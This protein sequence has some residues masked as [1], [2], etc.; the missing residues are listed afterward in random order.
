MCS[1]FLYW[2][3]EAL[4]CSRCEWGG[5][6]LTATFLIGR[7]DWARSDGGGGIPHLMSTS[8][9]DLLPVELWSRGDRSSCSQWVGITK[10][11]QGWIADRASWEIPTTRERHRERERRVLPSRE[12]WEGRIL[13]SNFE[14]GCNK[15]KN[16]MELLLLPDGCL[17]AAQSLHSC[18][19]PSMELI[20]PRC[21]T[22]YHHTHSCCCCSCPLCCHSST[23]RRTGLTPH[24]CGTTSTTRPGSICSPYY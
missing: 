24:R 3:L 15:Y 10:V 17:A 16:K 2:P 5:R 18:S 21:Y 22:Q 1:L 23:G 8:V 7:A 14:G 9:S 19:S 13:S 11:Q 6:K 20:Q 4:L 12:S